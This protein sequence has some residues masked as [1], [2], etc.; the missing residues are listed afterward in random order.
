MVFNKEL[1]EEMIK[2][3]YVMSQKHPSADLYIYNYSKK[4]QFEDY[5]NEV[6]LS[7]RGLILNGNGEVVS[8]C[9]P[10]FFNL[11]QHKPEEIPNESFDVFTKM[12]GSYG[13]SYVLNGKVYAAS[14]GSF[15]SDQAVEASKMLDE[16]YPSASKSILENIDKTYIFEIIYPNNRIVVDYRGKRQLV[17]LAVL[18]TDTGKDLPLEDIG[19]PIAKKHDG[20]KDIKELEALEVENEEGFVVLFKN[21][22]RLKVKFDEY[23]RLHRVMTGI[24]NLDLW[25]MRMFEIA[26][27]YYPEW[28]FTL[29]DIL[30]KVPDEFY[31]WIHKTLD[32]FDKE[33]EKRLAVVKSD[34]KAFNDKMISEGKIDRKDFAI[35]AR[36]ISKKDASLFLSLKYGSE[37]S[38]K[39]ALWSEM[40][41]TYNTPFVED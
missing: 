36:K 29:D 2:E 30:D 26:P 15:T 22:F 41:P 17:L 11:S 18:D 12:D 8:Q 5:W 28:K 4:A 27:E 25:R 6:T 21:G 1:F 31:D 13:V 34:F 10:K 23:V 39:R 20:I 32:D 37:T 14:R 9:L 40:R 33:Y 7:C 3:G 38:V 16:L 24:S 35:N 19:M